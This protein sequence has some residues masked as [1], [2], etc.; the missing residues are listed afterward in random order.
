MNEYQPVHHRVVSATLA[1]L[2]MTDSVGI[3]RTATGTGA[4][5]LK[6]NLQSLQPA[7]L[8][9]QPRWFDDFYDWQSRALWSEL[10]SSDDG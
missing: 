8:E 6:D 10:T 9:R 2:Q 1:Q 4:Y 3:L 5:V 7:T